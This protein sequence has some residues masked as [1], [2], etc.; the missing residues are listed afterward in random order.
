MITHLKAHYKEFFIK[1]NVFIKVRKVR[2]G[3]I[4]LEWITKTWTSRIYDHILLRARY[5]MV[6]AHDEMVE[7]HHE[8][9]RAHNATN[10]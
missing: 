10:A 2:V 6:P 7:G 1:C 3:V 8:M 9:V 4:A 5:E